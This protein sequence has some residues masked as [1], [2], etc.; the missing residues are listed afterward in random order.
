M[1][2]KFL[3]MVV[4]FLTA[5]FFSGA[6]SAMPI[7]DFAKMNDDD[8]A[9][10]VT[11]LVEGSAKWLKT[12][13]HPEQAQ[14]AIDFFRDSSKSGGLNQL[15]VTMKLMNGQ[16]NRNAINP[17]NRAHVLDVEDAMRSTLSDKGIN[18]PLK[19]LQAI[20]KNFSPSGLPR[21]RVPMAP[22]RDAP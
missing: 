6:A 20:N 11:A 18:V 21:P 16:N 10:Y 3:W 19:V 17:N 12:Q 1:K 14:K 9:T 13:G 2:R 15:V 7:Q 5:L 4:V 22:S 8:D